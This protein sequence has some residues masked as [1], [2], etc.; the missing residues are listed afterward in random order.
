MLLDEI[1]PHSTVGFFLIRAIHAST[2]QDKITCQFPPLADW[3]RLPY[4]IGWL[5]LMPRFLAGFL[6]YN[7]GIDIR[8]KYGW[9]N[10]GF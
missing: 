7:E 8:L 3:K 1:I 9:Q 5:I 2:L 4:P 6:F 10:E